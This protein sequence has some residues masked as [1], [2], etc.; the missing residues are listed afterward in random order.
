MSA[1]PL[2]KIYPVFISCSTEDIEIARRFRQ[3]IDQ[4]PQYFGYIARDRTKTFEY[5]SEKIAD[6]LDA[7]RAY[8]ILYTRSGLESPMVNQE[9]GYFYHRYRSKWGNK[10]PI[11]LV[12]D[13]EITGNIDGFA[14]AR[15]AIPLNTKVP[16]V[17]ISYMLWDMHQKFVLKRLEIPCQGHV[18]KVEWPSLQ[19]VDDA[20]TYHQTLIWDCP[21]CGEKVEVD[22]YTFQIFDE[23]EWN[24]WL[25]GGA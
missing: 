3:S 25:Y 1:Q 15:E 21:T 24:P 18:V 22:P 12:K 23:K 14:Y 11:I 9:F 20:A 4:I 10:P 16:Q 13:E 19:F 5:P 7:S 2:N 6:V 8:I 17:A